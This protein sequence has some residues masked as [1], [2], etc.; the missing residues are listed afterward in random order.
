MPVAS[1][2]QHQRIRGQI[3]VTALKPAHIRASNMMAAG[4]CAKCPINLDLSQNL[5]RIFIPHSGPP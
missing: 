2:Q 3:G 1:E 5:I 4:T